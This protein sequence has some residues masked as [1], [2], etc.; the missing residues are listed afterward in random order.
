MLPNKMLGEITTTQLWQLKF[1]QNLILEEKSHEITTAIFFSCST[2][3][4]RAHT[5]V[6]NASVSLLLF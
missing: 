2:Y 4:L 6:T 3:L 5:D 1:K